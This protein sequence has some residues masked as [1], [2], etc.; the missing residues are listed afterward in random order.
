MECW[1]P[2]E[3]EAEVRQLLAAATAVAQA[4][5][6]L[7]QSQREKARKLINN[8]ANISKHVTAQ[9]SMLNDLTRNTAAIDNLSSELTSA[10]AEIREA[11]ARKRSS[12]CDSLV[13][14][15][16]CLFGDL[17][18]MGLSALVPHI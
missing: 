1:I 16:S 9:D 12:T 15:I 10:R 13:E 2:R 11:Q 6:Y 8:I 17:G 5:T 4:Q 18:A 3:F 7:P 14:R